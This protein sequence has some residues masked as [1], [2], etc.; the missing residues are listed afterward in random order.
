MEKREVK[1]TRGKE[2]EKKD[3]RSS[4]YYQFVQ[5][6]QADNTQTLT[7]DVSGTDTLVL[8]AKEQLTVTYVCVCV[9][10]YAHADRTVL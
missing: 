8:P 2:K 10:S 3:V 5:C 6:A 7:E 9:I 1:G 4:F